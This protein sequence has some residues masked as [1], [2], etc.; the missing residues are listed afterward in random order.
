[1]CTLANIS[2]GIHIHKHT[3]FL[4]QNENVFTYMLCHEKLISGCHPE[5]FV[6]IVN[7]ASITSFKMSLFNRKM[8]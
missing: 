6:E 7:V 8:L 1:M 5:F 3:H 2:D 4:F